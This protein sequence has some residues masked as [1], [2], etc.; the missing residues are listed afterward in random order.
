[1]ITDM[2]GALVSKLPLTNQSGLFTQ[3]I[4]VDHLPTGIY[5][6]RVIAGGK[7]ADQRIS[8]VK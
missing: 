3:A 1:M 2:R 4:A 8:V 5:N 6:I 7:V